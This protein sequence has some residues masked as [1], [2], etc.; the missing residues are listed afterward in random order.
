L[1]TRDRGL[2]TITVTPEAIRRLQAYDFPNNLR[3]LESLVSRALTQLLPNTVLTE[4]ILWPSQGK[5]KLFRLN[6]LNAYPRFRRFLR[7]P[8]WPDRLNYGFTL[9]AFALVVAVLFLG[10]P[11]P[12]SQCGAQLVLGLVVA[13]GLAGFSFCGTAVVR[14]VPLHDLWGIDAN[15]VP[16]ALSPPIERLAAPSGRAVGRLVPVGAIRPDSAVGRTVGFR[17]YR[18]LIRLFTAVDHRWGGHFLPNF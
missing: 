4:E 15:P 10:P 11:N 12:R 14:R 2:P 13:F 8:W 18:L 1:S 6:L 7:S 9:T 3:E 16:Q 17:K 5:K